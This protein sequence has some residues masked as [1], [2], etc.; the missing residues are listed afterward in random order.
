MRVFVFV[1]VMLDGFREIELIECYLD[2][3]I[4]VWFYLEEMD[5]IVSVEK[6]FKYIIFNFLIVCIEIDDGWF[7]VWEM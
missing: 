3:V 2:V 7:V 5:K 4:K 1:R 6:W